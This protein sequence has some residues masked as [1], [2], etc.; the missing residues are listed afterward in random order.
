MTKLGRFWTG[1]VA[2]ISLL[3]GAGLSVAGNVADTYRTRGDHTDTLDLT[4]AA[5]WPI[6]V[7]LA[8]EMFV[9]P[10][11]SRARLFQ[12]WRW[13]GCL[14]VGGMA[15]IV[16]W[17][18]LNDLMASRGQLDIVSIL[19][20]LAIDGMAIMAT[21]LILSTRG[22]MA[23]GQTVTPA[24]ATPDI[25]PDM[26]NGQWTGPVATEEDVAISEAAFRGQPDI[27]ASGH[28]TL[29]DMATPDTAADNALAKILANANW[30]S[31][32]DDFDRKVDMAIGQT[33]QELAT[34]VERYVAAVATPLPQRRPPVTPG[35]PNEALELLAAWLTSEGFGVYDGPQ[36]D[37]LLAGWFDRTTRTAR[38]W[39]RTMQNRPVS[40]PPARGGEE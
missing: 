20:P 12:V 23:N 5:G 8:I 6:L 4:M 10:R 22:H 24:M 16:S 39:R 32:L 29:P 21:G 13:V 26:A 17:T 19:G 2:Y 25:R 37:L 7:L 35:I 36:V 18:H 30:S 31:D 27:V 34:E 33:G 9:S 15:M 38:R 3:V 14:A 11:W 28:W 40:G 1:A